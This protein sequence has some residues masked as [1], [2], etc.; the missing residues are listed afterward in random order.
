MSWLDII[1]VTP[2]KKREGAARDVRIVLVEAGFPLKYIGDINMRQWGPGEHSKIFQINPAY[3]IEA[4]NDFEAWEDNPRRTHVF[5]ESFIHKKEAEE[6]I[7]ELINQAIHKSEK[8]KY[9]KETTFGN[10]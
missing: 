4:A 5:Q 7:V 9:K 8:D 3:L 6:R 10:D 1:K 2:G